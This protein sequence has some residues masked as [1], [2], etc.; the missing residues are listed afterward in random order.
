MTD[1]SKAGR[2]GGLHAEKRAGGV[3]STAIET[4]WRTTTG[5]A[6][7][8][9]PRARMGGKDAAAA[10]C[11]EVMASAATFARCAMRDARRP[12]VWRIWG[13]HDGYRSVARGRNHTS[14]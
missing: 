1:S 10:G 5:H 12:C 3:T 9:A 6:V 7:I 4:A 2:R 11:E 14:L 8:G 13:P